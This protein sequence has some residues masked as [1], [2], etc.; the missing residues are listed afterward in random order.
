MKGIPLVVVMCIF[1]CGM[2]FI[3]LDFN[4]RCVVFERFPRV[5]W[6]NFLKSIDIF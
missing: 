3:T 4:F 6:G 1:F 5:F 2:F